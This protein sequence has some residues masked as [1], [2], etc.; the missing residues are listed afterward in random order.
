MSGDLTSAASSRRWRVL[1]DVA[2]QIAFIAA[3]LTL[4]YATF[5]RQPVTQPS[6]ARV[7][8]AARRPD[9]PLPTE[10]VSLDGAVIKGAKSARIA[11]I[12]YSDFQCP[13]CARFAREI[14]PALEEKYIRSGKVLM[15]FRHYPLP[16][17]PLAQKAAEAAECAGQQGKFWEMHDAL[18][19]DPKRLTRV[20]LLSRAQALGL[21]IN[22][23]DGCLGGTMADDVRT[24]AESARNLG[25][26]G[27]PAFLIGI[28]QPDG[29][30]RVSRRVSGAQPVAAFEEAL[31]QMAG[32]ITANVSPRTRQ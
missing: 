18:F 3:A 11:L 22:Q 29:R 1:L 12:E 26:S 24:D 14:L 15:A 4:I 28:V 25:I 21:N 16:N 32:T 19:Q 6:Q 9:P 17:H 5:F 23:F 10:P 20:D 7:A 13:F 8:P 30:V 2:V 27:T 31:D